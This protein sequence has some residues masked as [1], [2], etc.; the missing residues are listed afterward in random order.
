MRQ[1]KINSKNYENVNSWTLKKN[2][3]QCLL[4][5]MTEKRSVGYQISTDTRHP[6]VNVLVKDLKQFINGNV[7]I[8]IE[9]YLE[10]N[11]IFVR[12]PYN[13]NTLQYTAVKK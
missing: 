12:A 10:R 7:R 11:Y 2:G 4:D 13:E 3:S 5:I 6:D 1:V 9:E 8:K